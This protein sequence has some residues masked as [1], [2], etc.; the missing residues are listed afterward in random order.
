MAGEKFDL[1]FE[2][3]QVVV[4]CPYCLLGKTDPNPDHAGALGAFIQHDAKI[5]RQV[6]E[7]Y[8]DN[9]QILTETGLEPNEVIELALGH[10]ALRDKKGE[11]LRVSAEE[12]TESI[13]TFDE[14]NLLSLHGLTSLDGSKGGGGGPSLDTNPDSDSEK[15][16]PQAET[17]SQS[18]DEE[19]D[20]EWE[21]NKRVGQM[22]M[23]L[24]DRRGLH[25]QA[26]ASSA[27]IGFS[28]LQQIENGSI[29]PSPGEYNRIIKAL[30]S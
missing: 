19:D 24:R 5:G 2:D 15:W 7:P 26:I 28:Y 3:L 13:S 27:G 8:I 14:S 18:D 25:L 30:T 20:E 4:D 1:G 12:L 21:N 22:L 16:P 11:I 9:V 23:Q 10:A 29:K 6:L 17:S